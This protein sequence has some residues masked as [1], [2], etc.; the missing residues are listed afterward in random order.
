V[1]WSVCMLYWIILAAGIPPFLPD[2]F[3]VAVWSS[4]TTVAFTITLCSLHT[5]ILNE[6][7]EAK[8]DDIQRL[9]AKKNELETKV[10][11]LKAQLERIRAAEQKELDE[12]M[13]QFRDTVEEFIKHGDTIDGGTF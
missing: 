8:D 13:K 4:G 11:D 3:Q 5:K 7:L 6:R 2:W 12:K 1:C 10:D 9:E